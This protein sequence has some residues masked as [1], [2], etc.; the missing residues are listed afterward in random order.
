MRTN[1][2]QRRASDK[3]DQTHGV[4]DAPNPSA[5]SSSVQRNA[6]RGMSYD[7]AV[8]HLSPV[9]RHEDAGAVHAAAERGTSGGGGRLPHHDAIQRSFG[10]HDVGGV[11]AHVGGKATEACDAMG[12]Q[13]YASG[14]SVAFAQSPDLHTAAHEAAHVVQ[15]RAGV[16][17]KGGVGQSGDPYERHADAV[18]DAVVQGRSAEGLLGDMAGGKGAG[19][20]QQSSVQQRSVQREDAGEMRKRMKNADTDKVQAAKHILVFFDLRNNLYKLEGASADKAADAC[21]TR[22]QAFFESSRQYATACEVGQT[23][24]K[25]VKPSDLAKAAGVLALKEAYRA[26]KDVRP[27]DKGKGPKVVYGIYRNFLETDLSIIQ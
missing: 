8:Q 2:V 11:S 7:Q 1:P 5:T 19:A 10:G 12:A 9:Q 27:E 14:G 20:V 6:L 4:Q 17:L 25:A 15:Q 26:W 23:L 22:V 16:A 3:T 18:A 13:A 21:L 24:V